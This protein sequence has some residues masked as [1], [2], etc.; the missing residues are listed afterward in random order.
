MNILHIRSD[1][2]DWEGL[3]VNGILV[4][5]GHSLATADVLKAVGLHQQYESREIPM[6]GGRLPYRAS[7]L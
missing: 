7:E 4:L 3:Y 5:E 2:G 1:Q 6:E